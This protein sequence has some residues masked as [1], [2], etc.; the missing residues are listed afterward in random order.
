M[1]T[2][3]YLSVLVKESTRPNKLL[4]MM[5]KV[6]RH[7]CNFQFCLTLIKRADFFLVLLMPANFQ[8]EYDRIYN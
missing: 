4:Q 7:V 2:S 6:F 5:A 8:F 3:L 1:Q